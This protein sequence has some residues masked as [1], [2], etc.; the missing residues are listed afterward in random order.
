MRVAS[1]HLFHYEQARS[2]ARSRL[3]LISAKVTLGAE[4]YTLT[5]HLITG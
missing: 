2:E 5:S 1:L 3:V 4:G